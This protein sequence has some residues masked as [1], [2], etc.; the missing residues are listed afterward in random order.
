M[1]V[2]TERALDLRFKTPLWVNKYSYY[3]AKPSNGRDKPS[4]IILR[5]NWLPK[6]A[7]RGYRI[8][9]ESSWNIG[10][11]WE[12][13]FP[14]VEN[15]VPEILFQWQMEQLFLNFLK[16]EI[17]VGYSNFWKFSSRLIFL[18]GW[19]VRLSEIQQFL[20]FLGIF[21]GNSHIIC[22]QFGIFVCSRQRSITTSTANN[23][24]CPRTIQH[25]F[26]QKVGFT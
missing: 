23:D 13:Q 4:W 16:Q 6:R 17:E 20:D 19:R 12:L 1:G 24:S 26:W 15:W 21:S 11:P 10:T 5:C 2:L 14:F 18:F 25:S 8:I 22:H 3:M 7:S 9:L